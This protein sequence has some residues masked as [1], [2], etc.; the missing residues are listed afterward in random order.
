MDSEKGSQT[1]VKQTLNTNK[2]AGVD[3]DVTSHSLAGRGAMVSERE[4]NREK[5]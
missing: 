2:P 5:N 4:G 1:E 3:S